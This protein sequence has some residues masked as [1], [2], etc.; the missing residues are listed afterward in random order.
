MLLNEIQLD[1]ELTTQDKRRLKQFVSANKGSTLGKRIRGLLL[2]GLDAMGDESASEQKLTRASEKAKRLGEQLALIEERKKEL[3]SAR[4]E[5]AEL[6]HVA[7]T[8]RAELLKEIEATNKAHAEASA[9]RA[10]A[11]AAAAKP[12]EG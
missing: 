5:V 9:A 10:K 1:D 3:A 4:A 11:K 2:A 8:R 12:S 6:E 7:A